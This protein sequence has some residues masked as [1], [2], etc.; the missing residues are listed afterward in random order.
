MEDEII[1]K[2]E[3]ELYKFYHGKQPNNPP[4]IMLV[5]EGLYSYR[6]LYDAEAQNV[7][8]RSDAETIL[9]KFYLKDVL[10]LDPVCKYLASYNITQIDLK[11][12]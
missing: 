3:A 8:K 10:T 6:I 5:A 9:Y 11:K 12:K 4:Q 1:G 7:T 2:Q